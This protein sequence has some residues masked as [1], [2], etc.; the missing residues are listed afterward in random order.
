[1]YSDFV[2]IPTIALLALFM[3]PPAAPK[4]SVYTD[5][6]SDACETI[7]LDQDTGSS[8][9]RCAGVGGYSLLVEDDDARMSVT[10]VAPDGRKFAL[11]YWVVVTTGFSTV[12]DKAE[13]RVTKGSDG[14][15]TPT[16]LIVRLVA[17]EDPEDSSKTTSY[18]V[19]ATI[20]KDKAC[21]V[22]KVPPGPNQNEKAREIADAASGKPCLTGPE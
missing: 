1:M 16:A 7:E 3:L 15:V 19:V 17:S 13:W 21:V 11:N 9:Q 5:I 6:R 4:D 18:L 8:T 12:G 10:V 20:E 14:R 2:L 22:A